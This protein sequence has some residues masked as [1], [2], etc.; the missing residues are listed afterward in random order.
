MNGKTL[1]LKL[2]TPRALH[3]STVSIFHDDDRDDDDDDDDDLV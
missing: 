1:A 2:M 3:I